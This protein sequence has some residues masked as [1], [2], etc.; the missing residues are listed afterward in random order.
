MMAFRGSLSSTWSYVALAALRFAFVLSPGLIHPDEFAQSSQVMAAH[1]LGNRAAAASLPWEFSAIGA[2]FRSYFPP[3]ATSGLAYATMNKMLA[4]GFFSPRFLLAL[5]RLAMLALSFLSD[6]LT[7]KVAKSFFG[8]R[9]ARAAV[10]LRASSWISVV[11]A[12][13]TLSNTLELFALDVIFG[14]CVLPNELWPCAIAAAAACGFFVRITF[15]AFAAPVIVWAFARHART[16]GLWSFASAATKSAFMFIIYAAFITCFDSAWHRRYQDIRAPM[17][18]TPAPLRNFMYNI[19]EEN[20]ANHGLHP[21]WT[22][23]VVN[24]QVMFG[25]LFMYVF[26]A[27][28]RYPLKQT[29]LW[30]A[31]IIL[32][33]AA[34]SL[35]PHQEPR[36]L[37]PLLLP[38]SLAFSARCHR[39]G[40]SARAFWIAWTVHSVALSAF[41]GSLHQGGLLRAAT[42]TSLSTM[43]SSGGD[44][45]KN[46]TLCVAT[47]NTYPMPLHLLDLPNASRVTAINMGGASPRKVGQLLRDV[48]GCAA[49]TNECIGVFL[50]PLESEKALWA[51]TRAVSKRPL[52]AVKS[53]WP[54]LSTEHFSST[55]TLTMYFLR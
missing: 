22:H 55:F 24:C 47:W 20:L 32:P 28:L 27:G 49:S 9:C 19:D 45:I 51:A 14:L 41:F 54:H 12:S 39:R 16:R 48:C 25:P 2:P 50:A 8:E 18:S 44:A 6:L 10:L 33:L 11:L 15:P 17:I 1:I 35:F 43:I 36:F 29:K 26:F 34:L 46:E 40:K 42:T 53:F 4:P 5:P 31:S 52:G 38:L 37:A 30:F 21:R 3:A 23:L 13:R 7:W